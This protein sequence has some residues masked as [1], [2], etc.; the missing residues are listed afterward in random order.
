VLPKGLAA[1]VKVGSWPVLPIFELMKKIGNVPDADWRRTF[2]LG[3]GMIFVI[4]ER[5]LKDAAKILKKLKEPWYQI[6]TIAKGSG[7]VYE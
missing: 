4:A 2:N 3:I 1:R 6:G 5:D 7:V